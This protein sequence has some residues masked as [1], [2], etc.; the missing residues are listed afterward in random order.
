MFQFSLPLGR[1]ALAAT[2]SN[3]TL[4]DYLLSHQPR[5]PDGER[6]TPSLRRSARPGWRQ[7]RTRCRSARRLA[8]SNPGLSIRTEPR[9]EAAN[10]LA[11]DVR[12]QV[13][14][15]GVVGERDLNQTNLNKLPQ[16]DPNTVR[17]AWGRAPAR[18]ARV[19]RRRAAAAVSLCCYQAPERLMRNIAV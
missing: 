10:H 1:A 9:A 5:K 3:A 2:R 7:R 19:R 17:R 4:I 8:R 13:V 11:A 15:A 14:Y 12:P 6:A 18:G 16:P